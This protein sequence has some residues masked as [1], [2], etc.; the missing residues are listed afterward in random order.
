MESVPGVIATPEDVESGRVYPPVLDLAD[1]SGFA[2]AGRDATVVVLR[3]GDGIE[4]VGS[5]KRAPG[6]V[7]D[8]EVGT[9]LALGRALAAAAV[10]YQ[11][12]AVARSDYLCAARGK[13]H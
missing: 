13:E 12:T 10:F 5:A 6:D 7:F 2:V 1:V 4:F 3:F 11:E 8:Q 9:D